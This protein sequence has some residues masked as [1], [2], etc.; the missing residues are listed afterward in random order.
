MASHP[1]IKPV[2]V[3]KR[4]QQQSQTQSQTQSQSQQSQSAS[5]SGSASASGSS[6]SSISIPQTAAAGG[7]TLTQPPQTSTSFYKIASGQPITFGWNFTSVL[8]NNTHLTV[9]AICDNG[10]TYPVGPTDGVIA[11]T[12]T[13]VVWDLYSYNQA[14]SNTPLAQA[15]YTL[16]IW[17]DLGRNA[18]RAPGYMSPNTALKFA[19]YTPQPYTPI[20]SGK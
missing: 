9:S 17:G 19:L 5:G 14:H 12:A 6:S 10:N 3:T 4:Q 18:A 13:S 2:P 16:N 20:S 11:G 7:I 1:T 8:V 15:S